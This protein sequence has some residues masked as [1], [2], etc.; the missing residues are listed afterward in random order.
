MKMKSRIVN[1]SGMW[2]G[3]VGKKEVKLEMRGRRKRSRFRM[4]NGV[5]RNWEGSLNRTK[6]ISG[7]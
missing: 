1:E 6:I 2:E 7:K 5:R 3:E 4:G